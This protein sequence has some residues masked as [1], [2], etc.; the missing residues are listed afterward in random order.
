MVFFCAD[1]NFSDH[2]LP[3]L[4]DD[5]NLEATWLDTPLDPFRLKEEME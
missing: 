1:V 4:K 2:T 5:F 3:S